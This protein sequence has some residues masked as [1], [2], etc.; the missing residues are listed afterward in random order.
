MK[1]VSDV[2]AKGPGT[3]PGPFFCAHS[4]DRTERVLP[5]SQGIRPRIANMARSKA[6]DV[7]A[8]TSAIT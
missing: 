1:A 7:S 4:A 3:L 2:H 6:S 8:S 5:P